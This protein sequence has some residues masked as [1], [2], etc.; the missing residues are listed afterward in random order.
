MK[1]SIAFLLVAIAAIG[2]APSLAE[3]PNA[4]TN[5]PRRQR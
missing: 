2:C 3:V 1:R 5:D 4:D